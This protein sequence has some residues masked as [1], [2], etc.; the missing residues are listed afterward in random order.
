MDEN[1]VTIHELENNCRTTGKFVELS[2]ILWSF[3]QHILS[4]EL[5]IK[6]LEAKFVYHMLTTDKKPSLMDACHE[7]KEHLEIN[8]DLFLKVV[9]TGDKSWC[10][11]CKKQQSSKCKS[12]NSPHPQSSVS[13][14]HGQNDADFFLMQ[15]TSLIIVSYLSNC[16]CVIVLKHLC[17]SRMKTLR[18][19]TK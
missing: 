19:L 7:L 3:C 2:G 12:S 6:R 5:Q 15:M 4:D 10:Y 9:V 8:P 11:I 17:G 14:V 18:V 16:Y 1:I 13:K